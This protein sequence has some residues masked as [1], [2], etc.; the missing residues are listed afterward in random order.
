[1]GCSN[2]EKSKNEEMGGSHQTPP[3]ATMTISQLMDSI[4]LIRLN[5]LWHSFHWYLLLGT[6]KSTLNQASK[7]TNNPNSFPF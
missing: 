5:E 4:L 7:Q 1:M 6:F 3:L 2:S